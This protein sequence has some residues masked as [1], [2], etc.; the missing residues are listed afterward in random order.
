MVALI[1]REKLTRKNVVHSLV[2]VS[3]RNISPTNGAAT[4]TPTNSVEQL[5]LLTE[6]I[7]SQQKLN[8]RTKF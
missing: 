1:L 5:V 8:M 7:L 6:F 3:A 2:P 4:T